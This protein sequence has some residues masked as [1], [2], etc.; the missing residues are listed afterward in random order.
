MSR[1]HV[2]SGD[3]SHPP[4]LLTRRP[5]PAKVAGREAWVG[6]DTDGD[7]VAEIIEAPG[8]DPPL[9]YDVAIHGRG[10]VKYLI[11]LPVIIAAFLLVAVLA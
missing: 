1:I 3:G 8:A 6:L 4:R 2:R 9:G 11:W 7:L 10:F 5:G